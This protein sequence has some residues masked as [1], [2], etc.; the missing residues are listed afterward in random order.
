MFGLGFSGSWCVSY[1][2]NQNKY[3]L[4][5]NMQHNLT[6]TNDSE[7]THEIWGGFWKYPNRNRMFVKFYFHFHSNFIN[8]FGQQWYEIGAMLALLYC[9]ASSVMLV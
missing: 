7:N 3:Y 9:H 1:K 2:K 4:P 8:C 6:R 5:V